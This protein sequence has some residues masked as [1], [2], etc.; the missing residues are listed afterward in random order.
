[1]SPP[2]GFADSLQLT[3]PNGKW[4]EWLSSELFSYNLKIGRGKIMIDTIEFLNALANDTP[5]HKAIIEQLLI[6]LTQ[7]IIEQ[8]IGV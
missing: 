3:L 5:E 2:I 7:E 8:Q 4:H 6:D 1:L